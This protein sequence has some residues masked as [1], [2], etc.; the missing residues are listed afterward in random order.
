MRGREHRRGFS[1]DHRCKPYSRYEYKTRDHG[2]NMT[3]REKAGNKTRRG[4]GMEKDESTGEELD[5]AESSKGIVPYEQPENDTYPAGD[6]R[7]QGSDGIKGDQKNNSK[8][9]GSMIVSSPEF[10]HLTMEENVT[11]R[12]RSVARSLAYSPNNQENPLRGEQRIDALNDMDAQ[13]ENEG[14]M[15][16]VDE[17]VDDGYEAKESRVPPSRFSTIKIISY[18]QSEGEVKV[19]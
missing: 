2:G 8:R 4:N 10:R 18:N 5:C 13:E 1:P 17:F 16:D 11:I 19:F 6:L 12:S 7:C 9:V 3:W 14:H 15:M